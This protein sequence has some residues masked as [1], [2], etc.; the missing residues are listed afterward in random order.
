MILDGFKFSI[1]FLKDNLGNFCYLFI[2]SNYLKYDLN[3]IES[4]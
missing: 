2:Q 4:K 1:S 3:G